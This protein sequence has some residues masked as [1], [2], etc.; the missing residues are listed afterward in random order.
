VQ[1]AADQ[2]PRLWWFLT[3]GAFIAVGIGSALGFLFG[4]LD[5]PAGIAVTL[6][7]IALTTIVLTR[8]DRT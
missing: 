6:S 5:A 8:L 3:F 2:K 4:P 1:V 7:L